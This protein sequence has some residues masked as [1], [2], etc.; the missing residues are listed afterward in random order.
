MSSA[1]Q[2]W[3]GKTSI[4]G[5]PVFYAGANGKYAT[6][7]QEGGIR[8]FCISYFTSRNGILSHPGF[9]DPKSRV[10]L[11]SGAFS[12]LVQGYQRGVSERDLAKSVNGYIRDYADFVREHWSRFDFYVTFDYRPEVDVT[13]KM[14]QR[15]QKLGIRPT[16]VYHG[17]AGIDWFKRYVDLGY[18]LICVS[19]RF[20]MGDRKGLVRFYDQLFTLT[21]R[22]GVALHGLACAT[23][24]E[25]WDYPWWSIDSTSLLVLARNGQLCYWDHAGRNRIPS[26]SIKKKLYFGAIGD[27][28]LALIKS[29]K[30]TRQELET[31]V[32]KRLLF[33]TKMLVQYMKTRKAKVWNRKTLF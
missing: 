1:L 4:D 7:M 5:Q 27:E 26:I 16:P 32:Y 10:F 22:N 17:D 2:D 12:Y 29:A 11:D 23:G 19:K 20:F 6:V 9:C 8:S 33:N 30:V 18:R 21:E 24:R 15:L 13:W 3:C 25:A 31:D 14:T 28:L